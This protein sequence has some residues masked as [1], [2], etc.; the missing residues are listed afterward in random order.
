M[1][2]FFSDINVHQE[3][4]VH[5]G[6]DNAVSLTVE[7]P[8]VILFNGRRGLRNKHEHHRKNKRDGHLCR[9]VG[10]DK[11]RIDRQG[12]A[13]TAL[14]NLVAVSRRLIRDPYTVERL[15][16]QRRSPVGLDNITPVPKLA[17]LRTQQLY[18]YFKAYTL[19]QL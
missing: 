8:V 2:R 4:H 7:P 6:H 11:R 18:Q 1:L 19:Y 10:T 5:A 16:M 3:G 17:T 12:S 13:T 9:A 15:G 14:Y